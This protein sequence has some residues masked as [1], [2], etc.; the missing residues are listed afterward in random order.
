MLF[1]IETGPGRVDPR[2]R[3][4]ST[5]RTSDVLHEGEK[6]LLKQAW[7]GESSIL[8]ECL[9]VHREKVLIKSVCVDDIKLAGNKQNVDPLWKLLK[10]EVNL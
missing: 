6:I 3:G 7:L 8:G 9:F 1:T 10:K 5:R 4:C 2:G